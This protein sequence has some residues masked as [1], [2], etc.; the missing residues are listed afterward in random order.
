MAEWNARQWRYNTRLHSFQAIGTLIPTSRT[1]GSSG[2]G[3][4]RGREGRK[5]VFSSSLQKTPPNVMMIQESERKR[6]SLF[7]KSNA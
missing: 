7:R 2:M 1:S 6:A 3:E 4:E 5:G